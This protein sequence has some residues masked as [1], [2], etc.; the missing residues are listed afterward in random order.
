M[1]R[2]TFRSLKVFHY[3]PWATT[4]AATDSRGCGLE[5][6]CLTVKSCFIAH[7]YYRG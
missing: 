3:R 7:Q 6:A 2:G 1:A 4:A 5:R